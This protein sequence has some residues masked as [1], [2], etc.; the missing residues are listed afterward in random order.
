[1]NT[2]PVV[3]IGA[4]WAGLAAAVKL[5]QQG[6]KVML[7]E[8]AK[9]AGGRARAVS[10]NN[11]EV[12]N[13]QHLLIGAYTECLDLMKTVGINIETSLKEEY[14]FYFSTGRRVNMHW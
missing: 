14:S 1:M 6:Q 2:E 5:T 13:G 4:G 8:S 7:F 3:I 10:F 11:N 12:D 9:Q